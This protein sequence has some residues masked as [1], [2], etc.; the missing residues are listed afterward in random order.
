MVTAELAPGWSEVDELSS[1]VLRLVIWVRL[2]QA[3]DSGQ[4][5][6]T[7]FFHGLELFDVVRR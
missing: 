3:D 2:G 7:D 4:L 6:S 1:S 5:R